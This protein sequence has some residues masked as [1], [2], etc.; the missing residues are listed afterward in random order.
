MPTPLRRS[1]AGAAVVTVL[2]ALAA[3]AQ[4]SLPF[5]SELMAANAGALLDE[6][7]DDSDWIEIYNPGSGAVDLAGWSLTDDPTALAKWRFPSTVVPAGAHLVVFASGKNRARAGEELHTNFKLA[8]QGEYLA[9]VQPDGFSI[10][11]EF[12]PAF[13]PLR[14]NTSYG[15]APAANPQLLIATGAPATAHVPTSG[16]LGLGWTEGETPAGWSTGTTGVGYETTAGY[17][18][19]IGLD[20]ESTMFQRN[21]SAYIRVDFD[22]ADPAA[23]TSLTLRMQYDDGFVAYLNGAR[24]A[25]ANAPAA[26]AWNSISTTSHPDAEA[27]L[28]VDF[29]LSAHLGL[30]QTGSNL[31]A[32]HGLN[33]SVGSSDFLIRPELVA[34]TGYGATLAHFSTSTPNGFPTSPGVAGFTADPTLS[35]DSGFASAPFDVTIS[36]P[37]P[38]AAI[39]YTTDGSAPSPTTSSLYGG[40]IRIART[41]CLRAAA[42]GVGLGGSL[43][44]TKTYLF[45]EDI[46]HQ[47]ATPA[48]W[49]TAWGGTAPG[50]DYEMDPEVVDDPLYSAEVRRGLVEIPSLSLVLDPGDLFGSSGIY[51]N[52]QRSGRSWE[53]VVDAELIHPDGTPGFSVTCGLRIQGGRSRDPIYNPKH[54]F[55]L[56]FRD[57]YGAGR[58]DH[59]V[60]PGSP[61]T[62]FDS[63]QIRHQWGHSFVHWAGTSCRT[64]GPNNLWAGGRER[65]SLLRE[66]WGKELSREMGSPDAGR[67]LQVNLYLNGLFWGVYNLH[68][69]QDNAHYA[70]WHGG[71]ED[72]YD[73]LSGGSVRQGTRASWNR[74]QTVVSNREWSQIQQVLALDNYIDF[75]IFTRYGGNTDI[76]AGNNWRAAGGGPNDA[77]WRFYQWDIDHILESVTVRNPSSTA[78]PA[79]LLPTLR[80]IEE[81]RVRFGD[82]VHKHFF[83]GGALTPARTAAQWSRLAAEVDDAIVGESARWGDYRRDVHPFQFGPYPLYTKYEHVVPH[84]NELMRDFFPQRTEIVL[85]QY[86]NQGLYPDVEAP[87]LSQHGGTVAAG[88]SL[89]LTAPAAEI[90]FT[91]DGSDPRLEG[92]AISPN[93]TLYGGPLTVTRSQTVSARALDDGQWSALARAPFVVET[94][95]LNEL[96]ASN[97]TGAV[98]EA[99]EHEDWVELY[100]KAQVTVTA[101]G[102]YL[103]DDPSAPTKW[104]IPP[105]FTVS[106][107][108]TLLIWA[109][110]D[111]SQGPLHANFKLAATGEQLF[112]FADDGI[113]LL[114]SISFGPQLTDV[115]TGRWVDGDPRWV[116]FP[117]PTA[118]A[119]NAIAGCGTRRYSALDAARQTLLL[120]A[121]GTPAPG[122]PLSLIA[123]GGLANAPYWLLLSTSPAESALPAVSTSL[124]LV[125][126]PVAL[127]AAPVGGVT[128]VAQ[129]TWDLPPIPALAGQS[130]VLQAWAASTGGIAG[131]NGVEVVVCGPR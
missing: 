119:G 41:T 29:D 59:P 127:L 106:P 89:T 25:A 88:F 117:D 52:P 23:L 8:A 11:N 21:G 53:R 18:T 3:P 70:A 40:P 32:I 48:G 65:A 27:V 108:Q 109:D 7:G 101:S 99:G 111:G 47:P 73:A 87:V 130:L 57:S 91:T 61:V 74:M 71:D 86:R 121:T 12:A 105:G 54:S 129:Y 68:E 79:G 56:R 125:S 62:S 103:S 85:Q 69:R 1:L 31:L 45:V 60:F 66:F 95:V 122:Q 51:S 124:L 38:G 94:L 93:A 83:A 46:V 128:G 98:D 63:L 64:C 76:A 35:V 43:T 90:Y 131:S 115:S 6:D 81:F 20:L 9:L 75:I 92:G 26:L 2:F 49:P 107:G 19:L 116:T 120:S 16:A 118:D 30:L 72:D 44:A 4:P 15:S 33:V 13:P 97:Q 37:T 78:D 42:F 113:T 39:Y 84:R 14:T 34:G 36:S 50:A 100:N 77:P 102:L 104:Q 55:S 112:L 17:E 82:R 22:V 126:P 67:G 114:D 96:L 80:G 28:F 58:L 5:V 110:E 10:A 24:V 123:A